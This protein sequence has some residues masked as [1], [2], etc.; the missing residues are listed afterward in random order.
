MAPGRSPA[1]PGPVARRREETWSRTTGSCC[2]A[3]RAAGGWTPTLPWSPCRD[4]RRTGP[5]GL[6]GRAVDAALGTAPQVSPG[7]WLAAVA[8]LI[9]L[10]VVI[11]VSGTTAPARPPPGGGPPAAH[12]APA[13]VR[14]R[15]APPRRRPVGDLVGRAGRSGRPTPARPHPPWSR[16]HRGVAAAGQPGGAHPDR[17]VARASPS[18]PVCSLLAL[19]LRAF[20]ADASAAAAGYQQAQGDLAGRLVESLAGARTIAAAGTA[21]REVDRVLDPAAALHAHGPRPGRA[22][23]GRRPGPPSLSPLLA[24]RRHRRRRAAH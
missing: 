16:P 9:A 23:P 5:A 1:G 7:R 17:P 3:V 2:D 22:G 12:P 4:G 13:P 14:P 21:D 18:S 19:L 11:G 20:V 15:P 10:L 6:L 8:G 24:A